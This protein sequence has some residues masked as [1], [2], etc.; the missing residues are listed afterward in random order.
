MPNGIARQVLTNWHWLKSCFLFVIQNQM[1]IKQ[2]VLNRRKLEVNFEKI[3]FFKNYF[4]LTCIT[5]STA[6][7]CVCDID[8]HLE[9]SKKYSIETLQSQIDLLV[10]QQQTAAQQM[11]AALGLRRQLACTI[12]PKRLQFWMISALE[13]LHNIF[14]GARCLFTFQSKYNNNKCCYRSLPPL[15][16]RRSLS[17]DSLWS[18]HAAYEQCICLWQRRVRRVWKTDLL[19]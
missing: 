13:Y 6:C 11:A 7:V 3:W 10:T 18:Q 9:W 2:V 16:S 1:L 19:C 5:L 8:W 14:L 17:L 4:S 12:R 15:L